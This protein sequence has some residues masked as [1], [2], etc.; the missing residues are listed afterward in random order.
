MKKQILILFILLPILSYSQN[1]VKHSF[2]VHDPFDGSDIEF[3][4]VFNKYDLDTTLSTVLIVWRK[5]MCGYSC[6]DL[7]NRYAFSNT[8]KFNLILLNMDGANYI[9]KDTINNNVISVFTY[10]LDQ[11]TKNI[12]NV[13][14]NNW[15]KAVNLY[16]FS[17]K[18]GL[19]KQLDI[20]GNPLVIMLNSNLE[21]LVVQ[22][23]EHLYPAFLFKYILEDSAID[24]LT[25]SPMDIVAYSFSTLQKDTIDPTLQVNLTRALNENKESIINNTYKDNWV[26]SMSKYTRDIDL[27][28]VKYKYC[29]AKLAYLNADKANAKIHL[30]QAIDDYE[31]HYNH[32][33]ENN[34]IRMEREYTPLKDALDKLKIQIE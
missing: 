8:K 27:T 24:Y 3:N 1:R 5:Q 29:L 28:T 15:S 18:G 16:V 4:E 22:G 9:E 20:G 13:A 34:H 26:T 12:M 19:D 14:K 32:S 7:V 23:G 30:K 10:N 2:Y 17:A 11:E 25:G 33:V 6:S 21:A 31:T